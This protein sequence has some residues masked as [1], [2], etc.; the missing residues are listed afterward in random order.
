MV[1]TAIAV[2]YWPTKCGERVG[3]FFSFQVHQR[4]CKVLRQGHLFSGG[5]P[6]VNLLPSL[7]Q[8]FSATKSLP[9]RVSIGFFTS[10]NPPETF[11]ALHI[12]YPYHIRSFQ[13][14]VNKEKRN[15]SRVKMGVNRHL[16]TRTRHLKIFSNSV[17]ERQTHS[18]LRDHSHGAADQDLTKCFVARLATTSWVINKRKLE[19]C[20]VTTH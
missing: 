7:K 5:L 9:I 8:A 6:G 18:R 15:H 16:K 12:P 14:Q 2:P 17:P 10:K 19:Q 3:E 20:F 1:A 13:N 4:R 11:Y